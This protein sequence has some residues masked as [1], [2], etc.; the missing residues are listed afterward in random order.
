MIKELDFPPRNGREVL[1]SNRGSRSTIKRPKDAVLY[2]AYCK[3][4]G[5]IGV[6]TGFAERRIDSMQT[7]CPFL[8]ELLEQWIVPNSE[9]GKAEH[10]A[11]RELEHLHHFGEWFRCT[12]REVMYVVR[13]AAKLVGGNLPPATIQELPPGTRARPV[14]TPKGVFISISAAANY[15]RVSKQAIWSKIG[16]PGWSYVEREAEG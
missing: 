16:M 4:Y 10:A 5:K 6:T 15:Y 11:M 9:A 8:I 14:A 1:P 2:A 12:R 7:G 3:G 13:K